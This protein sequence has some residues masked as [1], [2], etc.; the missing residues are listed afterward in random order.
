MN[1]TRKTS[2][3]LVSAF[4]IGFITL[5][6]STVEN[7]YSDDSTEKKFIKMKKSM[8][9]EQIKRRGVT[10][11]DVINA[12]LSVHRH[13]FV[14]EELVSKAY[15]DCPLPIG[16]GQTI[17]QPFIVAY[18]TEIL[19]LNKDDIVL[20][21]GTGSGYQAAIL[22]CLVKEVYTIEIIQEL[23]ESATGRLKKLGYNN[24]EVKNADGYH[25]W[26]EHAPFDAIIVT[27]A[28]GHIPP[29][30]LKQLQT[31]GR[32]IIPVGGFFLTQNLVLIIKEDEEKIPT[33]NVMPV[34][35]VP[36]TGKH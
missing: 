16:Y 18:M 5:A 25:G 28:A 31:K 35:F 32:M 17:S 8:V 22:S 27:A 24:V 19:K 2:W 21:I 14:P 1:Q 20:E 34:R 3:I 13:L 7:L 4:I 23:A 15:G 9:D 29:P 10:D 11:K 26:P 30:L 6:V 12:M 36:L 33:Q